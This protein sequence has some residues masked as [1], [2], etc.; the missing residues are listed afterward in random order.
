MKRPATDF[1]TLVEKHDYV[2]ASGDEEMHTRR[3][4]K[5]QL[6]DIV[7]TKEGRRRS[8]EKKKGMAA[9]DKQDEKKSILPLL[10]SYFRTRE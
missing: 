9:L 4:R 1:H 8:R 5:D 10:W 3:L 2:M 7:L 6:I